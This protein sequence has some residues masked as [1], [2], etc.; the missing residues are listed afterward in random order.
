MSSTDEGATLSCPRCGGPQSPHLVRV[1]WWVL[2]TL[3][4]AGVVLS[5]WLGGDLLG[6]LL[7]GME[8]SVLPLWK[9]VVPTAVLVMAIA[10]AGVRW[11]QPVCDGCQ[12]PRL[13][14]LIAPARR[15]AGTVTVDQTRRLFL[16]KA[17]GVIAT[18][19]AVA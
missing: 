15:P 14:W 2:A 9:T 16:W 4:V 17:G 18:A 1:R 5:Y 11:H 13:H 3:Y 6:G 7:E 10:A 8:R 19:A 12:A